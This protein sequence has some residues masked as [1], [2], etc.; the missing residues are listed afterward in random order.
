VRAETRL[1]F[2]ALATVPFVLVLS[3]SMLIPVLPNI[4][5]ALGRSLLEVGLLITAFSLTAGLVIPVGGYLS[6]RFGR[7]RV[8]VPSL[9]LFGLGGLVAAAAPILGRPHAYALLLAGRVVQGIGAGGTYQ[10]AMALVGDLFRSRERSRALGLLEASNGLG[11]VV[12][13]IVGAATMA[14][15][16]YAPFLVYPVVAWASAA[17]VATLVREPPRAT[18][19]PGDRLWRRLGAVFRERGGTL[20]AAFLAGAVALFFLFGILSYYSDVLERRYRV[21]GV[22]RGLVIAIPVFVMALT[23]YLSGALLVRR[24]RWAKPLVLAGLAAAA[25][26]FAT[27]FFV[28]PAVVPFTAAITAMGLGNGLLLPAL[29]TMIT[30]ATSATA[31]GTVTALYGTVRF[32]GAALGP[33]A[34][35]EAVRIGP[36]LAYLG[37]AALAACTLAACAVGIDPRGLVRASPSAPA[38]PRG[39]PE[40]AVA[41]RHGRRS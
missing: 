18:R 40:P 5:T 28:A 10:V 34:F 13:P 31:R 39:V 36:A 23:A 19:Q 20:G 16:W 22:A 24:P 15:A 29:N 6:D 17:L 12:S 3:N 33:P 30:S 35:D 21:E 37:P 14:V 9:A 38:A 25:A 4:Q 7:K 41:A 8:M 11:K 2:A 26:A 1:P 27:M 32:L